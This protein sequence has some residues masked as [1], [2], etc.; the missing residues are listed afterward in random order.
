[1]KGQLNSGQYQFRDTFAYGNYEAHIYNA[2]NVAGSGGIVPG[3]SA[4]VVAA[5]LPRIESTNMPSGVRRVGLAA[6]AA[7]VDTATTLGW[8]VAV[9]Q[10]GEANAKI[11][12]D[13]FIDTD[14]G[15]VLSYGG[16]VQPDAEHDNILFVPNT[17]E[18]R[19][20]DLD[21]DLVDM[22]IVPIDSNATKVGIS[23]LDIIFG[24]PLPIE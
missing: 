2:V 18:L 15:N 4:A 14:A 9:N 3:T 5:S 20:I 12:I 24:V 21:A 6:T 23:Q 1:M 19:T 13:M 22:F 10:N 11:N 16:T 7:P 8:I 17:G